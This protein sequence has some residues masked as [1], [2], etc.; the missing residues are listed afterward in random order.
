ME[1]GRHLCSAPPGE[2]SSLAPFPNRPHQ[3]N[4]HAPSGKCVR[5]NLRCLQAIEKPQAV[6]EGGHTWDRISHPEQ[7]CNHSSCTWTQP[8][9]MALA[10]PCQHYS[11][12]ALLCLD[13]RC[14]GFF[15]CAVSLA[16]LEF[17]PTVSCPSLG[18]EV[19]S[20]QFAS[21][22]KASQR[23]SAVVPMVATSPVI[24]L[25]PLLA[26]LHVGPT[27]PIRPSHRRTRHS[28]VR[29]VART[30]PPKRR[31]S[32]PPRPRKDR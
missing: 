23:P 28:Q 22:Q 5:S 21:A 27:Q 19:P 20:C 4:H 13:A 15:A 25:W 6:N 24:A 1:S 9:L 32:S 7:V 11:S 16:D 12:V 10:L 2:R 17:H 26:I 31:G 18:E 30:K 3:P 14:L 29:G 8:R